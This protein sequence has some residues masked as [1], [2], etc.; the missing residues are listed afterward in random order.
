[1][2]IVDLT[3]RNPVRKKIAGPMLKTC[4][5]CV[6]RVIEGQRPVGE[7]APRTS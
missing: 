7:Q 1:L 4:A 5:E 6:R 3:R 2:G